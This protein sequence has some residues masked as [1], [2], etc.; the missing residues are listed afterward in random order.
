MTFIEKRHLSRLCQKHELDRAEIDSS[1]TYF[2]NKNHLLTLVPGSQLERESQRLLS[3]FETT[4]QEREYRKGALCPKC[5]S[6]GSGL[7]Q[8]WVLN[9]RKHKYEPYYYFAHSRKGKVAW[10][11]IRKKA[12][13]EIL[14]DPETAKKWNIQ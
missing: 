5:G 7:H 4:N 1:L 6:S 12:A 14:T 10:C 3:W 8:K 9:W 11:Y 2:E 13:I